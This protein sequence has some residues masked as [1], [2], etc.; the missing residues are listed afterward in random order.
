MI[1]GAF[2]LS[3]KF[4]YPEYTCVAVQLSWSCS[5]Y[6]YSFR[7]WCPHSQP[8]APSPVDGWATSPAWACG[9][10]WMWSDHEAWNRNNYP[11]L[12]QEVPSCQQQGKKW[13]PHAANWEPL[14]S[15]DVTGG[16]HEEGCQRMRRRMVCTLASFC[17]SKRTRRHFTSLYCLINTFFLCFIL[18]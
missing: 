13:G 11:V 8:S 12:L 6:E 15:L 16:C 2:L 18:H 7:V 5:R 14:E 9:L 10:P 4:T 1:K 17:G 3:I